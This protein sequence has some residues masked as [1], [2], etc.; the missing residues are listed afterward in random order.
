L[1]HYIFQRTGMSPDKVMS[2]PRLVRTFILKSMELQIE[3]EIEQ[4][5]AAKQRQQELENRR[6]RR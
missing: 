1:L 3:A 6:R 4:A 2:K 5:N